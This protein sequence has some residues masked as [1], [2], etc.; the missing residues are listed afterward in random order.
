[1]RALIVCGSMDGGFT[2]EMCRS[3]SEGISTYGITS[4]IIFPIEMRIE[5]CTGCDECSKDG[6][7]IITDDMEKI[8]KAFRESD[9]LVLSTP[10]HFSGP[11]SV[12][13]AVIDRFQP[14]W[15]GVDE[16]PTY[17]AALLSGGGRSPNFK[18]AQSIFKA[19]SITAGMNWLGQLEIPETDS[20]EI[21]Y[22]KR[23]SFDYGK[24]IGKTVTDSRK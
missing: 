1:M 10:I 9:L 16:H 21:S 23:T 5:H 14:L 22:V 4:D 24:E 11:S 19:F 7:C 17:V 20:K 3:F 2:S 18:N 6:K 15:F 8:Y 13:K 12:I